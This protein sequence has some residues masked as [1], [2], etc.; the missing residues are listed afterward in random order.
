MKSI[1][2]TIEEFRLGTEVMEAFREVAGEVL[3]DPGMA[4]R[5]WNDSSGVGSAQ[6][7]REWARIEAR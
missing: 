5:E 7:A 4:G 6:S 1:E 3:A 2:V